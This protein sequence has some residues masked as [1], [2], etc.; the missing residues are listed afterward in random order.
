MGNILKIRNLTVEVEGKSILRNLDLDIAKDQNL[1]LFGPNGSGKSTLIGAIMG[2]ENYKVT[3]GSI[4]FTGQNIIGLSPDQRARLGVGVMF[5][6]PPKIRGIQLKQFI[7]LL[8]NKSNNSKEKNSL[9]KTLNLDYLLDRDLNVDLSGG[10]IK[11]S[12]LLQVLVQRPKLLLLD[13]P[14]SGVDLENIAL[15]GKALNSYLEH[16]KLSALIISH[17]GYILEYIKTKYA[18]VMLEGKVCCHDNPEK[19]FSEIKSVGYERC[20]ECSCR[21]KIKK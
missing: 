13:E 18:C 15:M 6:H 11:R 5:Q 19:I 12:E 2:F 7:E 10:E 21:S 14:E 3:S 17:T 20:K 16:H 1:I 8:S 9:I 4:E